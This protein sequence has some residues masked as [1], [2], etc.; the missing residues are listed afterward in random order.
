MAEMM[1]RRTKADQVEPV[2]RKFT[3]AFPTAASCAAVPRRSIKK[4]LAPLG[5]KW[6]AAHMLETIDHLRDHYALRAPSQADNLRPIPGVGEYANSMLR[7]RLFGE[8][9]PA[10]DSNM[11]RLICR[12]SGLNFGPESR[13]NRVVKEIAGELVRTARS[14]D[15][16]LAVL[17]FSALVC[18]PRSPLCGQCPLVS[19]C[20]YAAVSGKVHASRE[21]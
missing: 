2:Y 9:L 18:K 13:R 20:Q 3:E 15:L 12:V 8:P 19:K 1:L 6:R 11:A 17:D 16:N 7:N 21:R 14:A 5:L 4:L 10:L